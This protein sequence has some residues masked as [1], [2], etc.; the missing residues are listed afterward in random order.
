MKKIKVLACGEASFLKSGYAIYMKNILQFLSKKEDLEVAEFSAYAYDDDPRHKGD[1]KLFGNLPSSEEEKQ[2]YDSSEVNEFGV[3]KFEHVCVNFQPD[4]VIDIRDHWHF[5]HEETTP[6]KKF[7]NWIIMPAVDAEPQ[8]PD[9]IATFMN[10][11]GVLTY[12]E[13]NGGVL[14]EQSGGKIKWFGAAPSAASPEFRP[15]NSQEKAGLKKEFGIQHC[16]KIVGTVMR[17]QG[18][19]LFPDLFFSFSEYIKRNKD[20]DTYL[21]CHTSYPDSDGWDIPY[22]LQKY[23]IGGRVLFTYQCAECEYAVPRLFLDAKTQCERCQTENMGLVNPT[24]AVDS[25]S[26]NMIYNCFDVYV[27]YANSEGFGMPQIEAAQ[28]GVPIMS[29]DYSAMSDIVRRVNGTPIKTVGFVHEISTNC[30]RAVP[31]NEDFITK[32][33]SLLKKPSILLAK[34]GIDSRNKS[35]TYF[36]WQQTAEKWYTTIKTVSNNNTPIPWNAP[37]IKVQPKKIVPQNLN[38]PQYA[39]WL[40]RNVLCEP[41][42]IGTYFHAKLIRDL[43]Y[44]FV[45]YSRGGGYFNEFLSVFSKAKYENFSREDAY[46]LCNHLAERRNNLEDI[47]EQINKDKSGV[48]VS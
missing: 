25:N 36:N 34:E 46:N 22:Y 18:R 37:V 9:W 35:L 33:G 45:K 32:L 31:D 24:I 15:L 23:D 2:L 48:S 7:Y 5:V 13:W 44:G 29:V 6:Y 43:N 10:A 27:Q 38:N 3:F 16:K 28:A 12:T 47:R 26:M 42:K 11:D 8:N 30:K 17:N 4:I 20:K 40:I 39:E 19:K 41:E 1:W 21:W 14:T